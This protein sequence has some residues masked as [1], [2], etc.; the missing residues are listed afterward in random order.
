M[1]TY[2]PGGKAGAGVYQRIIN[3]IPAHTLYVEPF[4]GAGAILRNKRPAAQSIGIDLDFNVLRAF[5]APVPYL[6][7]TYANALI[8][9]EDQAPY[10]RYH[11]AMIYCDP[12]YLFT[13]RRSSRPL[14]RYEMGEHSQHERLLRLLLALIPECSIAISGYPSSLYSE[15]L[16]AWRL[17]TFTA[18]TRGGTP[19]TECLWMSYPEP[20]ALH[21][22]RYLGDDYRQRERIKRKQTRWR[23]RLANMPA[24]ERYAMLSV[25]TDLYTAPPAAPDVAG[26]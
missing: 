21:D 8:W 26:S 17:V 25:I 15:T 1:S 16:S 19:A 9:L 7:L 24:A 6:Q 11:N 5:D 22:Y 23:N 13:A 10:L 12:P 3:N 18:Q 4:L 20:L 14:Y 2:Y